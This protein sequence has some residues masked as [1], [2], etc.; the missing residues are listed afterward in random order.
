M[1]AIRKIAGLAALLW[2]STLFTALTETGTMR[3]HVTLMVG[4]FTVTLWVLGL[5]FLKKM[6]SQVYQFDR[7]YNVGARA[8]VHGLLDA[9]DHNAGTPPQ[10]FRY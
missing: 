3:L 5:I 2:S 4:A 7:G 8:V 10:G 6:K 9:A 1:T